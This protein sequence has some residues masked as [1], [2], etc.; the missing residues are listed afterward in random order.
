MPTA[1][2]FPHLRRDLMRRRL[3]RIEPRLRIELALLALMLIAFAFWQLR[4]GFAGVAFELGA[5]SAALA[6]VGTM[7]AAAIA[8][9]AVSGWRLWRRLTI[10]PAGPEW[11]ALPIENRRLIEHQAWEAE[12][13]TRGF[14]IVVVAAW[15]AGTW[16]TPPEVWVASAI[17]IVPF[18]WLCTRAGLWIGRALAGIA[19]SRVHGRPE[20]A[21]RTL[22]A[23]WERARARVRR[24]SG[25][26]RPWRRMHAALAIMA[27]D[28][29]LALRSRR[30]RLQ[31]LSAVVLATLSIAL[32]S[33]PH[34]AEM[35]RG[36]TFILALVAA[37]SF[38]EWLILLGGLDPFPVLRSLPVSVG[39]IWSSRMMWAC[40]ATIVLVTGHAVAARGFGPGVHVSLFWLTVSS[41]AISALAVQYGLTMFP[42]FDHALRLYAL[43]LA[44]AVITSLMIP[45]LG[46]VALFG[47][48]LHSGRRLGR[49]WTLE[50]RA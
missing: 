9:A 44:L 8:A 21:T 26:R 7:G 24:T 3:L 38:G 18:W 31:G 30:V 34:G 25:S 10:R 6:M 11:L 5:R 27:R 16:I 45:L 12:V 46:W 33:A 41:M 22:S 47:A 2:G 35:A 50:E 19:S 1:A 20:G 17:L 28:A 48:V 43:A 14:A 42:R 15:L 32:W 4:I 23:H 37:A 49:W 13:P 29:T 36:W 39:T 40:I